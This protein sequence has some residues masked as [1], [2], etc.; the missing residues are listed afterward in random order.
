MPHTHSPVIQ[1]A[2]IARSH[3][4]CRRLG[5]DENRVHSARILSEGELFDRL[6]A[7]RELILV[8]EP[9]L[10][11][12]YGFV[13]GSNF[14]SM[15][16]DA[17]G[18]ILSMMGDDDILSEAFRL[19]M[20]PGA[21]MDERSIG[22]NA[23]G[24]CLAEGEPVQVSGEEHFIK[25][26]HR[27]TCSGAPIRDA[28]GTMI[29]AIDLTGYSENVHPHT[30]GMV[31]AAASAMGRMLK[32]RLY[33]DQ[34]L[35]SNTYL[36]AVLDSITAGIVGVG[37]DGTVRTVNSHASEMFGYD[38]DSMRSMLASDLFEGWD[39]VR[40]TL[41]SGQR[42]MDEDVFVRAATNKLQFN[43]AAYPAL[44]SG[45]ALSDVILVFKDVRKVRKLANRIMGRRAIYTFDKIIGKAPGFVRVIEFAKKMADSRSNILIMG[46]SGTGKELFAQA[47]H[48]HSDR[49]D[50]AFIAINCAAIPRTLIESELFGYEEGS[51]TGARH[52]G[53]PGKFEVADGGTVFLDEIG[54]MPL[55]MQTRLL[56][57]IE[58]G[59]V[60]R[61]GSTKES[62]VNVRVIAATNKELGDEVAKGNFRK[63]LFYRL[64]VLPMRLPPLR[65]RRADIPLL[66][67]FFM[68]RIT[69]KLNKRPVDIPADRMRGLQDYDWPGNIRELENLVEL[70]VN[71]EALP[72]GFP[73]GGA[74]RA[75]TVGGPARPAI[76]APP[77]EP[78]SETLA[79]VERRH[80]EAVLERHGGNVSIAA[81]ALRIGRNTLYRKLGKAYHP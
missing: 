54:E 47:I 32:V 66:V 28:D 17:D 41:L 3:E 25:A 56:R 26:Y 65:E 67:E 27:W 37:L 36:G 80:V 77:Q 6:E 21:F 64:N 68:D 78:D 59:T 42:F 35:L 1:K 72:A 4:R 38:E 19:K 62:V 7:R 61:I 18:C 69:R 11:Q 76:G 24:T 16:T 20:A 79:D 81:K 50:E 22:T 46:E 40:R 43:L 30:L 49:R 12:L 70:M 60:C 52:G 55:D 53:Q 74:T 48:N 14:F 15:L 73:G 71:A 58:E 31:V 5:V 51:F 45:G 34:L 57:V 63:D 10:S 75:R 29:G 33:N 44:D 8:A 23:M 13:R 2:Y 39:E 9:F